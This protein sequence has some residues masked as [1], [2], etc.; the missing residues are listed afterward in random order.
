M[1]PSMVMTNVDYSYNGTNYRFIPKGN[2]YYMVDTNRDNAR[3]ASV[4]PTAQKGY[5]IFTQN[6]INSFGYFTTN[7]DFAVESYDPTSDAILNNVYKVKVDNTAKMKK[8]NIK[9]DKMKMKKAKM[10]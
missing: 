4:Y 10:K 9:K 2:G 3:V 6:G 1:K 8:N 5:Y 7:G